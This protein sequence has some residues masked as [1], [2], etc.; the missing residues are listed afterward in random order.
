MK[1]IRELFNFGS[2]HKRITL[3][4]FSI[5]LIGLGTLLLSHAA[6]PVSSIEPEQGDISPAVSIGYGNGSSNDSYIAFGSS[7]SSGQMFIPRSELMAKPTSGAGWNVLKQQADATWGAPDLGNGDSLVQTQVLAAALIY[8]RTGDQQYKIKVENAIKQAP[9]T[10]DHSPVVLDLTRT[11]YGYV[12]AADLVQMPQ[13]TVCNNGQTWLQFLQIIRTKVLPIGDTGRWTTLEN[14]SANTSSNWGTYALGSHLAVSYALND[15]VG[16]QR[17]LDIFKRFLGDTTSPAAPFEPSAGYR[18]NNNGATW[19]MTPTMQR[20]INPDSST[21][22]RNGALIE[23]V[24][25]NWNYPSN[26]C[27]TV[28][29][30]GIGYQ[31]ESIDAYLS[32]AQLFK[33]HGIDLRTFQNSAMLRAFKFYMDNGGHN[34]VSIARYLPYVFNYWYGT[35]YSTA[36]GDYMGRHLGYGS[37]LFS[38]P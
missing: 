12:I 38:Q 25:R 14:T 37:W 35:S 27:C 9:G 23:D 13:S 29:S 30:Y 34:D 17:D 31:K 19:D 3:L 22:S 11:I 32:T 26:P 4:L 1:T 2:Q 5:V 7:Q 18:Y 8:A 20:G 6:S 33:A 28:D 24:L 15:Q 36:S 16:I 21:D 10:E